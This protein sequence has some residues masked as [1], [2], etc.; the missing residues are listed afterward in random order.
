[1]PF[2]DL[3]IHLTLQLYRTMY[4]YNVV[5]QLMTY[6]NLGVGCVRIPNATDICR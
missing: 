3:H 6:P 4:S 5:L 1:M 2:F